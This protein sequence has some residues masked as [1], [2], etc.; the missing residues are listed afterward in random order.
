M[1]ARLC[2]VASA[3]KYKEPFEVVRP[4]RDHLE[5]PLKMKHPKLIF[6]NSMSDL[7]HELLPESYIAEVFDVMRRA[8][9]HQFQVLTKR[10]ERLAE[11]APRLTWPT[12]VWMG[13]SVENEKYTWRI[14]RLRSVPAKRRFVSFEPLL[15]AIPGVDLSGIHWA[16]VGGESGPGAR[17]CAAEW[18]RD[19]RDQCQRAQVPFFFKQW[20]KLAN[21]PDQKDMTAKEFGG[22]SKGGAMLDGRLW[23]EMPTV[24]SADARPV[25]LPVFAS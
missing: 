9:W 7:F 4:W 8:H 1:H 12:N 2:G 3:V 20:G 16:I 25:S 23:R 5:M 13:V 14:D 17:P 10:A 6:V 22:S 19:L 15:S 21:N 11:T 24:V 18:V